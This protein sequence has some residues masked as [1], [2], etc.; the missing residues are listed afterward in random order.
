MTPWPY[1]SIWSAKDGG[2][3]LG[4]EL[5]VSVVN[6]VCLIDFIENAL[7]SYTSGLHGFTQ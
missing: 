3:W 4:W 5:L 7:Y 6:H 2:D 1:A